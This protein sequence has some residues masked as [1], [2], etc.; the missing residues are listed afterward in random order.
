MRILEDLFLVV[1]PVRLVRDDW[2]AFGDVRTQATTM[3]RVVMRVDHVF[4]RLARRQPLRCLHRGRGHGVAD[5][6]FDHDHVILELDEN[7]AF[8]VWYQ[9]PDAVRDTHGDWCRAGCRWGRW[10]RGDGAPHDVDRFRAVGPHLRDADIEYWKTTFAHDDVHRHEDAAEIAILGVG[11]VDRSVARK[12]V[13]DERFDALD[14]V[15]VVERGGNR[16]FAERGEGHRTL[17]AHHRRLRAGEI[18]GRAL[19]KSVRGQPQGAGAGLLPA[20][21]RLVLNHIAG[22]RPDA[23]LESRRV[24]ATGSPAARRLRIVDAYQLLSHRGH[25]VVDR[26]RVF[27]HREAWPRTT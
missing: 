18:R 26:E 13:V 5:G 19:Q 15:L 8:A 2:N 23:A 14:Y 22:D 1:L 24:I 20:V 27:R 3:V 21:E 9:L 4:D 7:A 25:G 6:R 17:A 11:A 12:D 10:R 16:K